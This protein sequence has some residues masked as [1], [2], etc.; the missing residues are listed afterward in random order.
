MSSQQFH[1][2]KKMIKE[3]KKDYLAMS[4]MIFGEIPDFADV[5]EVISAFENK[6]NHRQ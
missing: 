3:L 1:A 5:I 2:D 6:L 4:G